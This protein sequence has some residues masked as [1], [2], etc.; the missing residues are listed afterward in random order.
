MAKFGQRE[1]TGLDDLPGIEAIREVGVTHNA[2]MQQLH[3]LPIL[4]P[5]DDVAEQMAQ[6]ATQPI[7]EPVVDLDQDDHQD[8][9]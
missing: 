5:V 1:G 2:N 3:R 4:D 7:P 6:T 9:R 8:R